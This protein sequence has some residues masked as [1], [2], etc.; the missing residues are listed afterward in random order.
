[1]ALK[2]TLADLGIIDLIQFPHTGR[3]SGELVVTSNDEVA[4]LYYESGALIHAVLD[5]AVGMEAL[6]R[7]VDWSDGTF[8]FI[9][10]IPT[11]EKTIELDL[12]R[13]VMQAIKLHDELKEAEERRR[14]EQSAPSEDYADTLA[15]RLSEFIGSTNF[16]LHACVLSP[17][18]ELRAAADGPEGTPSGIQDL[19]AVIH[20]FVQSYPRRDLTRMFMV[21]GEGTVVTVRLA[22]GSILIVLA[23]KDSSL[24][25][26]SVSVGRLA[27]VLE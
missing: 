10:D 8:E 23:G 4:R 25:A 18:G 24:G 22:D 1:M 15:P 6:V 13:A 2:G 20:R 14:M 16:A 5:T 11:V 27:G 9:G 21:E 19:R 12:H 26:V 7:I 17:E 3:K